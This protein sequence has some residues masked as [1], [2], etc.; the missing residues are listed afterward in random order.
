MQ[1]R[2]AIYARVSTS[3]Q[4][5]QMQLEALREYAERRGFAVVSEFVDHGV[6]GTKTSRPQL[7]RL[8]D[9]ARK[10]AVDV[11]CVFR[12]DRMARS[13]VHLLRVLE[14]F[15]ALGVE[16]VS[17]SENLDTSTPMGQA[18]FTIMGALAQL[19]RDVLVERSVEGQRRA[20][21]RGKHVGRPRLEIN[22]DR[23]TAL[24]D[25]GKS[26]RE[27]AA[28]LGVSRKVVRRVLREAA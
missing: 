5:P 20:R 7:D 4:S 17:Y 25:Q 3:D 19:E 11:V 18:M 1:V 2:A 14:E 24:R 13:C 15:N 27:I 10:R 28:A 16:F 23:V 12:F 6:S 26:Q 9:A 8:M 21:A 22:P